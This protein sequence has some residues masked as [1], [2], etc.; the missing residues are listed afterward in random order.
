MYGRTLL[1]IAATAMGIVELPSAL[2]GQNLSVGIIGGSSL[3]GAA[4]DVTSSY[5]IGPSIRVW[6]PSKD[7]IVGAMVEFRFRSYFSLELDGMF[8]ELHVT[9]AGVM[10][11]GTL[12]SVSPSPVVTWE[13]PVLA[14]YRFGSGRLKPFFEAGPS[15]RTTGNLNFYPS[16]YGGAAGLGVETHWKRLN[17]AP[18]V[19]Y[20][21]W[22]RERNDGGFGHMQAHQLEFLLGI[23]RGSESNLNPIGS[24]LSLGAVAGWGLNPD[25]ADSQNS[26]RYLVPV[27]QPGGG[28]TYTQVNG[29]QYAT[30]LR[31]MIA[32]P[33]VELHLNSHLALEVDALHKT[34]RSRF[35][36]VYDNG[37]QSD[38]LTSTGAAMWQF[39]V[40]AKYRF[41]WG[42][43]NPFVEAGPS[44]RLPQWD[45]STHGATGGAGVEM[46]LRALNVAPVLRFTH[47]GQDTGFGSSGIARNEASVLV[48]FSFGGTRI[49]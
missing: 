10:P 13:F 30:G 33:S 49:R 41:R 27:P 14:K 3:T 17:F 22:A 23:S 19:R 8:R 29:T 7:W 25:F 43:V 24:R 9:W 32:G 5:L 48:G 20:T 11:D 45:L 46:H 44:F 21:R 15:F 37:V 34:L 31:S 26:S 6:S 18:V 40:L 47:W 42:K 4:Q 35:W 2:S 1:A 39:P 16:H 36:M 38:Y 12:N 28:Y